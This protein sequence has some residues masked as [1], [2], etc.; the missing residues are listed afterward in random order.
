MSLGACQAL[1]DRPTFG[2]MAG[3]RSEESI[4]TAE[5]G[6][7]RLGR[8]IERCRLARGMKQGELAT[9][10]GVNPSYLSSIEAGQRTWPQTVMPKIAAALGI[11]EA[12]FAYEAGVISQDPAILSNGGSIREDDP[13]YEVVKLLTELA[14]DDIPAVLGVVARL[15]SR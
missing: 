2:G 1:L 11:H 13:R 7:A 10:A 5:P 15:G 4:S 3:A 8:Y 12:F 6:P 14:D 9:R